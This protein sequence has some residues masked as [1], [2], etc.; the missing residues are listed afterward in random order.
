MWRAIPSLSVCLYFTS[1]TSMLFVGRIA[2]EA[3]V[4]E[5]VQPVFES[6]WRFTLT[7]VMDHYFFI[8]LFFLFLVWPHSL[9]CLPRA[10]LAFSKIQAFSSRLIWGWGK[11]TGHLYALL[12]NQWVMNLTIPPLFRAIFLL[13][14][15]F[16]E[17][18]HHIQAN[19][20]EIALEVNENKHESM[21]HLRKNWLLIAVC[22]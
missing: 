21:A 22:L 13:F 12:L 6:N 18:H 7:E 5:R 17:C 14:H 8:F 3:V 9:F 20:C 19:L 16:V 10:L 2:A 15:S 11:Q 1:G 4:S